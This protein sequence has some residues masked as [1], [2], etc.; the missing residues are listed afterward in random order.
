MEGLSA[1]IT[2]LSPHF[3]SILNT[4]RC[5]RSLP[6]YCHSAVLVPVGGCIL[7]HPKSLS[8]LC[9]YISLPHA[10]YYIHR[11]SLCQVR[12]EGRQIIATYQMRSVSQYP[13]LLSNSY[14]YALHNLIPLPLH[15]VPL[16]QL[17]N[18]PRLYP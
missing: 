18:Y 12:L 15:L 3:F 17:F 16:R 8:D 10:R 13:T 11:I 1:L 14:R 9:R 4:M 5:D 7:L 2:V 6:Q